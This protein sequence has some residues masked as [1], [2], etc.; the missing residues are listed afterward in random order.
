MMKV[1]K[2]GEVYIDPNDIPTTG[3]AGKK[4]ALHR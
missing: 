2:R 3:E 4:W 1:G